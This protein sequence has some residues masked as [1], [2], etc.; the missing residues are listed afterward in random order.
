MQFLTSHQ[1]G[2]LLMIIAPTL[3]SMAGVLTR[4][5]DAARGFEVTFWRSLF[6]GLFVAGA[7]L[8]QQGFGK[9]V[10]TIRAGGRLGVL[11]GMMWCVMF[12][13]FMIALTRTTVANTLIVMSVSPLL[14]AFLAWIVLGQRI[15]PRTWAAIAA[16]FA[17]IAWMFAS[18]VSEVEGKHLVGMLIA[19][20]VPV[21][22]AINLIAIKRAGHG[23][24]LIPSVLL[25]SVFA[26]ALMLPMAWPMQTSLHDIGILA[27]LGFF[28]LG[29]P[30]MLMVRAMRNLSAPEVSL[31]SL[32]EVLLGPI[33]A[34]LWA[35][36]VPSQETL[37]GGAVVLGALVFNELA[38]MRK[39]SVG[40]SFTP[41]SQPSP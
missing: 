22:A 33:W 36:E 31:L 30:C 25:G 41:P 17:G 13:C 37:V 24:D 8:Y 11:S 5:L 18:S 38:G 16:A 35:A 14:T 12:V 40:S 6:S 29:L 19:G 39:V 20:A 27:V 15:A 32:L 34:W 7:L 26:A 1:R 10:A 23:V 21:A 28:Q 9:T 4:H 3:W 2:I